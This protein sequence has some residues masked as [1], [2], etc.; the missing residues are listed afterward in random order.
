MDKTDLNNTWSKLQS[1]KN[2]WNGN[3]TMNRTEIF[4]EW[5]T[6]NSTFIFASQF[7]ILRVY[8]HF[9]LKKC[10]LLLFFAFSIPSCF[11]PCHSYVNW[12]AIKK[13]LLLLLGKWICHAMPCVFIFVS[14]NYTPHTAQHSTTQLSIKKLDKM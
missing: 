3:E 12:N 10:I 5:K 7:G 11:Y 2:G 8:F 4:S 6:G 13:L 14:T 1:N 9:F